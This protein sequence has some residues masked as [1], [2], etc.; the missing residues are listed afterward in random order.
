MSEPVGNLGGFETKPIETEEFAG[1]TAKN[2]ANAFFAGGIVEGAF[3][4]MIGRPTP[5]GWDGTGTKERTINL[6]GMNLNDA[7]GGVAGGIPERDSGIRRDVHHIGIKKVAGIPD[8]AD[9]ESALGTFALGRALGVEIILRF[10]GRLRRVVLAD[11]DLLEIDRFDLAVIAIVNVAKDGIAIEGRGA[12]PALVVADEIPLVVQFEEGAVTIHGEAFL[13]DRLG[14]LLGD[15]AAFTDIGAINVVRH[16]VITAP[17]E[18]VFAVIFMEIGFIVGLPL[19]VGTELAIELQ[20]TGLFSEG[21]HVVIEA[22]DIIIPDAEDDVG[23]AIVLLKYR[24]ITRLGGG[25]TLGD[26]RLAEGIGPGACRSITH[27]NAQFGGPTGEIEVI[28]AFVTDGVGG[29]TFIA[30]LPPIRVL[31][32]ECGGVRPDDEIG[33]G[34]YP[35]VI[36]EKAIGI[37]GDG[38]VG[39]IE[40][41][42][43]IVDSDFGIGDALTDNDGISGRRRARG[44]KKAKR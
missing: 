21:D 13:E 12:G 38:V 8:A 29:P 40:I 27:D 31:R 37:A 36:H 5:G 1:G 7:A 2:E 10:D 23:G 33:R 18:I 4:G 19:T 9:F 17:G 30:G 39:G 25:G 20:F 11:A 15:E 32:L 26:K 24:G 28:F 16:G 6:L 43:A 3:D 44:D 35:P 41:N 22:R 34:E 42:L 14:A